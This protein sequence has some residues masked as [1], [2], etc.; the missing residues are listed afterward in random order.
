MPSLNQ[1]V[2]LLQAISEQGEDSVNLDEII[3]LIKRISGTTVRVHIELD[4]NGREWHSKIPLIDLTAAEW[5]ARERA[6]ENR[7]INP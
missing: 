2:A 4:Y 6:S 1:I 5:L 7:R 3:K